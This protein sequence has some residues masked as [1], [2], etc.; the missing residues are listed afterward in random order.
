MHGKTARL[1]A[2]VVAVV[3]FALFLRWYYLATAIVS[4][5]VRGD[6]VQYYNYAWNL[7]NRH[8]FSMAPPGTEVVTP[9]SYRDPGYP[10]LMAAW[11]ITDDLDRW[12][13]GV[14][15]TQ[16][17]LGA[18]VAGMTVLLAR[19]WL[20]LGWS[21]VAGI[22]IAIWPHNITISEYLL[23][24]SLYG[25]LA[26]L[27]LLAYAWALTRH[28][29]VVA[30]FAGICFGLAILVNPVLLPVPALLF[31]V[32]YWRG[33]TP[34]RL[35]LTFALCAAVLPVAWNVRNALL[36]STT[37]SS[38]DRALQNLVQGSWPSYHSAWRESVGY[39]PHL[40]QDLPLADRET[41]KAAGLE[42]LTLIRQE[43][44]AMMQSPAEGM[45]LLVTRFSGAPIYYALWYLLEK[46]AL[47]W[48]W[49]IQIGQEFYINP[50]RYSPLETVPAL[51][52]LV[53]LCRGLNPVIGIGALLVGILAILRGRRTTN[54]LAMVG[55]GNNVLNAVAW[56]LVFV[57]L[58][59]MVLQAEPR[60]SIPYRP[61]EIVLGVTALA[62]LC[63]SLVERRK[64]AA[65]IGGQ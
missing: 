40:P 33:D 53:S 48:G 65:P 45:A 63:N 8:I 47:L 54:A 57:T 26:M 56:L 24:E 42:K 3:V 4:D 11:M 10:L 19:L 20:P 38:G 34:K 5:P 27:A 51:R 64:A 50:T 32:A 23:S 14:L 13:A 6:A 59:H 39:E 44:R 35:L 16:A 52:A 15:L 7:L 17:V 21:V 12:Y 60:Y 49:N 28:G 30:A 9:D 18:L 55:L 22:L 58:L 29:L 62:W 43:E 46:P 61:F 1:F 2:A 41:R 37:K 36:P 31:L 25:F